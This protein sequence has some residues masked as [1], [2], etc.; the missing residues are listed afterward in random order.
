MKK[1]L[2]SIATCG[3][4]FGTACSK[5]DVPEQVKPG[6]I[7]F[8]IEAVNALDTKAS[9]YS[10]EAI[11]SI[12]NVNV[13]VFKNTGS[14]LAPTYTYFSMVNIPNWTKGS[15]FMRY[16]V[17]TANNIPQGDYKFI[18]VG[19]DITDQFTLTTPLTP[20][21]TN[22]IDFSASVTAAGME[23]EIFSGTTNIMITSAGVRVPIIMSRQVAGV[24]GY[25]KNVP[26]EIG[27]SEVRYL[28]LTILNSNKSINLTSGIGS[29]PTNA[30]HN[31]IDV[32][33]STQVKNSDGTYGGNDLTA[34]NVVKVANSQLNGAFVIPVNN[35]TL[36]LALYGT[37]GTTV[38]K[39]WNVYDVGVIPTFNILPNHFYSLGHKVSSTSTTGT[40]LDPTPDSP[41]DLM[42][43]QEITIT[44]NPAWTLVHNLTINP[45]L[46]L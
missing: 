28:R 11:H 42:T 39:S 16:E 44:I 36:T 9:I 7:V 32:D 13:Y 23:N 33:L 30:T 43:D 35:V 34:Q 38:L 45:L 21:T 15:N 24:L 6:T 12:E 17:A 29:M 3:L 40:V 18:G 10:Q 26:V 4:L 8:D 31:L 46:P 41:I 2:L 22:Y 19:R 37:D 25:F 14:V 5:N 1:L 27:G 20:G